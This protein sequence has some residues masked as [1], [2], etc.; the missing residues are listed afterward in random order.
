MPEHARLDDPR[1]DAAFDSFPR[2]ELP[3]GF[4]RRLGER[5]EAEAREG[6][7]RAPLTPV[8]RL[9]LR[10][11]A[12]G[13]SLDWLLAACVSLASLAA[14]AL[15]RWIQGGSDALWWAELQSAVYGGWLD[16]AAGSPLPPAG[17]G[18][19][20]TASLALT[21]GLL[22]LFAELRASPSLSRR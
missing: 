7:V 12:L 18:L 13:R 19:L 3:A 16:L 20:L 22:L 10:L 9:Q 4:M 5:I 15:L 6:R 11:A 14:L 17:L 21:G 2:A 8:S 1:I